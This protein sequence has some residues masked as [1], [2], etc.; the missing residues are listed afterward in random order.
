MGFLF[1]RW[2]KKTTEWSQRILQSHLK[3]ID[4]FQPW[5]LQ[6]LFSPHLGKFTTFSKKNSESP[7]ASPEL[8]VPKVHPCEMYPYEISP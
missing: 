5:N 7:I 1:P 4:L 8:M 6:K 2:A 3:I